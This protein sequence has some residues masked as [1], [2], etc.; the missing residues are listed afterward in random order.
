MHYEGACKEHPVGSQKPLR[1]TGYHE[2]K[3]SGRHFNF[4]GR[5]QRETKQAEH[6]SRLGQPPR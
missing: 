5:W 6:R 4:A 3:P 2:K 1:I